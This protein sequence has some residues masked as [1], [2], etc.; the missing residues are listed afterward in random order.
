[1]PDEV[2]AYASIEKFLDARDGLRRG[3][4]RVDG[5]VAVFVFEEREFVGFGELGDQVEDEG[6][7]GLGGVW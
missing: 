7:E 3:K 5:Y 6:W 4:L 2:A 1:L